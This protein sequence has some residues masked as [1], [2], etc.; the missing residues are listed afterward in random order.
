MSAMQR[1]ITMVSTLS[2][3]CCWP[4]PPLPLPEC[5]RIIC[6][7]NN[8]NVEVPAVNVY[9]STSVHDDDLIT[10]YPGLRDND[11]VSITFGDQATRGEISIDF[12]DPGALDRLA[13]LAAEGGRRLRAMLAESESESDDEPA[14][15]VSGLAGEP[16]L[17]PL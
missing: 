7:H 13:A 12:H 3:R 10:L 8:T 6:Q 2:D 4:L 5:K 15:C 9:T 11:F 17:A 14:E 16:A 1:S